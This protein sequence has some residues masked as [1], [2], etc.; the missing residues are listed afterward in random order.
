MSG[1]EAAGLGD[2][3][4]HPFPT[5]EGKEGIRVSAEKGRSGETAV[6]DT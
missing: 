6:E 2:G 3:S 4:G 5:E 1:S